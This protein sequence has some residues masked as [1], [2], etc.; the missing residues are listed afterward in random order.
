VFG[1]KP[2]VNLTLWQSIT[3]QGIDDEDD[4][5]SSIRE[6][7]EETCKRAGATDESKI[8]NDAKEKNS[9]DLLL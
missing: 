7:L 2:R 5:P 9:N 6:Q 4:L 1:Q 8:D 3:E